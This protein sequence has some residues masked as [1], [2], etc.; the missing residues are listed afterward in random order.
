MAHDWEWVIE[1]HPN[2][3]CDIDDT[4]ECP[5]IGKVNHYLSLLDEPVEVQLCKVFWSDDRGIV[6]REHNYVDFATM[7]FDPSQKE[8]AK[9]PQKY[10]KQLS[11]MN[12]PNLVYDPNQ[13]NEDGEE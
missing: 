9:I 4:I 8:T 6:R 1:T 13:S 5:D 11:K 10:I 3:Q 7:Q 2:H 12:Q